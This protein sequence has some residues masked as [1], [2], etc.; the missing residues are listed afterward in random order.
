[1]KP[2]RLVALFTT[3]VAASVCG[4]SQVSKPRP[5]SAMSN[6]RTLIESARYTDA[7]R[8]LDAARWDVIES[9]R[10]RLK[11]T[12]PARLQDLS[13]LKFFDNTATIGIALLQEYGT[14]AARIRV[15]VMV[16][17]VDIDQRTR[18]QAP[19]EDHIR[20]QLLPSAD[21]HRPHVQG[22]KYLLMQ[23]FPAQIRIDGFFAEQPQML[24]YL[25]HA[26]TVIIHSSEKMPVEDL[27]MLAELLPLR[28]ID[29]IITNGSGATEKDIRPHPGGKRGKTP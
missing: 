27:T 6:W 20:Q 9:Y 18:V 8:A 12:L 1:M 25:S 17:T 21:Q 2:T 28:E 29:G 14:D 22:K 26:A 13:A 5:A 3:L 23:G 24:V 4:G 15:D 7:L 16:P 10:S 19:A 11:Q